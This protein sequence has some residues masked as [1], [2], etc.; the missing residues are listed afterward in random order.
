MVIVLRLAVLGAMSMAMIVMM[1]F[2]QNQ[3][4]NG[5]DHQPKDRND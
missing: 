2:A 3:H 5:V 1:G 4:T